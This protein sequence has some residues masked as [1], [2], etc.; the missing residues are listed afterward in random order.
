MIERFKEKWNIKSNFQL[1]IIILVFSLTGSASLYVRKGVF[2]VFGIGS[3]TALALKVL[4]YIITIIPSYYILLIVIGFLF[5][6]SEFALLFGKKMLS[7][8]KRKKG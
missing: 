7:R 8:F 3:D 5:G 1:V 4:L 2:Y 6:Q